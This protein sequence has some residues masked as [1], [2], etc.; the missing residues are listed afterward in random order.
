MR[1]EDPLRLF[2]P[3]L[4]NRQQYLR[5]FAVG[6]LHPVLAGK[7]EVADDAHFL[8]QLNVDAGHLAVAG[9]AYQRGVEG[10]IL[11]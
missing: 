7:I 1:S 3:L 10:F 5:V 6:R 2:R 11:S 9:G 4:R 8:G